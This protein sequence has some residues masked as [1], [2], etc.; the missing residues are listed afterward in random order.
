MKTTTTSMLSMTPSYRQRGLVA[1]ASL[2]I[3]LAVVAG[4][5]QLAQGY[6]RAIPG[7]ADSAQAAQAVRG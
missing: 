4:N 3:T 1:L 2:V 5:L 7:G 6:S